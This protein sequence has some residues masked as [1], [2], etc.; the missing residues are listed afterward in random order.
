MKS[1][2]VRYKDL[3]DKNKN[4]NLSLS[5]EEI[6]KNKKI[7]KIILKEKSKILRKKK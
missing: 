2:I 5:P 3:V 1:F 6:L 4:P 7:P